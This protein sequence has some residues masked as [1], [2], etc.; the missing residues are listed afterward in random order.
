MVT[1]AV[2]LQ[3]NTG[4]S[5]GKVTDSHSYRTASLSRVEMDAFWSMFT[6]Y[7]PASSCSLNGRPRAGE[8]VQGL[9]GA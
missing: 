5:F 3:R 8:M 1:K 6:V 9:K 7:K 2:S 4:L